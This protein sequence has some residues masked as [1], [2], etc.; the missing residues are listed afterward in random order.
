MNTTLASVAST[1]PDPSST[2][3]SSG[4]ST[5]QKIAIAFGSIIGVALILAIA[6]CLWI[7]KRESKRREGKSRKKD[8]VGLTSGGTTT[9]ISTDSK[10]SVIVVPGNKRQRVYSQSQ[11]GMSEKIV[12]NPEMKGSATSIVIPPDSIFAVPQNSNVVQVEE[13][14]D[15]L[16]SEE[17]EVKVG[18]RMTVVHP[19]K[20]KL[21]DELDLRVGDKIKVKK[22][23][24]D[25][26]GTGINERTGRSGAFR[27]FLRIYRVWGVED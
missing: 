11:G 24:D 12:R 3:S 25:G 7:R 10:D 5:S 6:I 15:G 19:Y 23:Y 17:R 2:S 26:W 9:V 13:T 16:E 4:L 20:G 18:D 8:R 1:L 22:V 21:K 14:K 27:E